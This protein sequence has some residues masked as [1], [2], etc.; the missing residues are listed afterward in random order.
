MRR[1]NG[2]GTL[3]PA[4]T[5]ENPGG[6]GISQIVDITGDGKLDIVG[7]SSFG[8]VDISP[9]NGDGTFRSGWTYLS[10][11]TGF[12]IADINRDG[13]LD[14]ITPGDTFDVLFARCVR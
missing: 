9:G 13:R 7:V 3:Q 12:A 11:P 6:S 5:S 1:G 14:I 10:S 8:T 2:D 4:V